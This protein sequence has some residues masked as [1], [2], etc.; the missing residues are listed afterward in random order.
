MNKWLA[1]V[2]SLV[3]FLY[4]MLA[5]YSTI[6][7]PSAAFIMWPLL[8]AVFL[9][10]WCQ[11]AKIANFH[12]CNQKLTVLYMHIP[13]M[14]VF[15]LLAVNTALKG[16]FI[17]GWFLDLLLLY[18]MPVFALAKFLAPNPYFLYAICLFF[19]VCA[20]Y[21]GCNSKRRQVK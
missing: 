4:G 10:L 1:P 19:M 15:T 3:P 12:L 16:T 8:G 13:G 5:T 18:I 17:T 7:M 9:L 20:A 2:F 21:L 6:R 11:L 14:L